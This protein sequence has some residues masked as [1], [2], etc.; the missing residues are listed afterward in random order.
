MTHWLISIPAFAVA[1]GVLVAVHEFGHFWVARRMGVK[2]LRYSIGFGGSLWSRVSRRSGTEYRIAAIPLGGYV[3]MLD[4]R[5]GEV[6]PEERHL[7]F[8]RQS[9][10]RRIAIVAAGPGIN[11]LFAILAYWVVFLLGVPGMKP[12]VG[13]VATGTPAAEVGLSRGD[14]V[15]AVAGEQ[16]ES[17]QSLRIAV[18][19]QALGGQRLPMTVVSD[20][21][22]RRNVSLELSGVSREPK[23]LFADLGLQPYQPKGVPVIAGVLPDSPAAQA[24]LAAGD[25]VLKLGGEPAVGARAMVQWV[26]AHPGEQV[27]LQ[28]QRNGQLHTLSVALATAHKDGDTIGRLGARIGVDTSEW[29][30]LRTVRQ[31][32]PLAAIPAAV[33]KTWTVTSLTVGMLWRMVLGDVSWRNISGPI[34]IANYAGKTA[35]I[36]AGAFISFLALVSVSL[37]VLNL[38]PVPVLDGGHLLYYFIEVFRGGRPLSEH[39]QAIGQQVGMAALLL[40][41]GLAF[42]ND[43]TRLFG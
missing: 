18:I 43:I 2:V 41:M 32:G 16:A 21:G 37:A 8:N 40:L 6:P 35:S 20:D 24:G 3:K 7:A 10:W 19:E 29:A 14:R 34:Q 13:E 11:F 38:L 22:L 33:N 12:I 5:E 28:V 31:F 27:S 4:E 9:V 23:Q 25:R 1:I 42:Y 36:S 39:V 17:W 26:Q 15:V 30:S